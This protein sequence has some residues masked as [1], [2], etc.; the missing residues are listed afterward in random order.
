M[1]VHVWQFINGANVAFS[2]TM[3]AFV[4][5]Y[6]FLIAAVLSTTAAM[7]HTGRLGFFE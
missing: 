1:Q 6:L 4:G 5:G 2:L 3:F 7:M